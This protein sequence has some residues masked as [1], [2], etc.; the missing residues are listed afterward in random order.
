MIVSAFTE[1]IEDAKLNLTTEEEGKEVG[2]DIGITNMGLR[3]TLPEVIDVAR[4][5]LGR[6]SDKIVYPL[7]FSSGVGSVLA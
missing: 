3:E 5:G 6:T 1:A 4:N 7:L 2:F